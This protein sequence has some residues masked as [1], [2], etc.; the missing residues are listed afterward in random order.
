MISHRRVEH[1]PPFAAAKLI[2]YRQIATWDGVRYDASNAVEGDLVDTEAPNEVLNMT[3]MLLVGL[4]G[5]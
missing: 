2:E 3:D 5:E 1:P 4:G